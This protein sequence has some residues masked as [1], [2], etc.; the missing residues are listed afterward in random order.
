MLTQGDSQIA[1]PN[2]LGMSKKPSKLQL[3]IC[4]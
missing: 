1:S 4:K 2:S 3:L